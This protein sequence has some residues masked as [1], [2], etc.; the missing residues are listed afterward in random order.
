QRYKNEYYNII[1]RNLLFHFTLIQNYISNFSFEVFLNFLITLFYLFVLLATILSI[2]LLFTI[3]Y[4][5]NIER[6]PKNALFQICLNDSN[7]KPV[8]KLLVNESIKANI[9]FLFKKYPQ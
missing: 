1:F 7:D 9:H 4:L 8:I 6:K 3:F 2:F 5:E